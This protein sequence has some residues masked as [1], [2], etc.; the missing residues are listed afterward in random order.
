MSV[1]PPSPVA[2]VSLAAALL[3]AAAVRPAA[4]QA[5]S[6]AGLDRV[7]AAADSGRSEE[8]R[9][10][11]AD[12]LSAH[13]GDLAPAQRAR[14]DFLRGR[15]AADPD[16]AVTAYS[17]VALGGELPWAA[18]A[19]LRL[20]QLRLARGDYG[21]AL[22]DLATLRADFPGD[23]LAEMSWVWTGSVLAARGDTAQ[24]CRAWARAGPSGERYASVRRSAAGCPGAGPVAQRA[25]SGAGGGRGEASGAG[26]A[27]GAPAGW[28][29]QL[30]AFS[31]RQAAAE[32]RGRL[33]RAG[34]EARVLDA[35]PSDGL[36]RVRTPRMARSSEAEALRSR[37]EAAGFNAIIV[38]LSGG[39]G[40]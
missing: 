39:E 2:V 9:G 13:A 18:A 32:L 34:F 33:A 10:L 36:Y 29:V 12:W 7:E 5:T 19:R 4:A 27:S 16:S 26:A 28:S 3:L 21:R 23:S 25:G 20:A 38:G 37:L 11:L 14:A 15:L 22:S 24:A 31:T 30:G 6:G 35:S 1:R 17:R 40:S 8:A